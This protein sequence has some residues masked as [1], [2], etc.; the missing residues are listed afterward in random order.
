MRF[1]SLTRYFYLCMPSPLGRHTR[2]RCGG[3]PQ[4]CKPGS[5][6]EQFGWFSGSKGQHQ[7]LG[8]LLSISFEA[9]EDKGLRP[10]KIM[11]LAHS[12]YPF[13]WG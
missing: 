2:D 7:L 8:R 10:C 4:P 13:V 11:S 9:G 6:V 12:T 1:G 3:L 5:K